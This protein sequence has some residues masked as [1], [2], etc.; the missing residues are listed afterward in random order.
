MGIG[1]CSFSYISLFSN[2][3]YIIYKLYICIMYKLYVYI[4]YKLYVC[5]VYRLNLLKK[6]LDIDKY[7]K[8]LISRYIFIFFIL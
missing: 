7:D 1:D 2:I 8:H 4:I 3:F 5:I 6:K